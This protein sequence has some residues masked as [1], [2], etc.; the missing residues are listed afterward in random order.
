MGPPSEQ[1]SLPSSGADNAKI[2]NDA[3]D[4]TG[5]KAAV[6]IESLSHNGNG[7]TSSGI[8]PPPLFADPRVEAAS[9]FLRKAIESGKLGSGP[10]EGDDVHRRLFRTLLQ[11]FPWVTLLVQLL[12]TAAVMTASY[13]LSA[14]MHD[15]DSRDLLESAF[16]TSRLNV[17]STVASGVGWALFVLLGFYIREASNRYVDAQFAISRVGVALRRAAVMVRQAYERNVWHDGD[18]DRMLAHMVAYP[19]ALKMALRGE[20]EPEQL[21][22]ILDRRDADDVVAADPPHLHCIRVPTAYITTAEDDGYGFSRLR[23]NT[24]PAGSTGRAIVISAMD[25]IGSHANAAMRIAHFHPAVGYI[26]HLRIFL[27]I[28]LMFLPL[29]LVQSSGLY[30]V[31]SLF[32]AFIL[33]F[34]FP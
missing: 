9:V 24:A 34:R 10:A 27:Y 6:D 26:N 14:S 18:M 19:I 13:F 11:T 7:S 20:K 29:T 12:W 31:I 15:E 22:P 32:C 2:L 4:E 33:T 17:S 8:K 30:V 23:T 16:W 28:W 21:Y 5:L 25:S 1:S 3:N